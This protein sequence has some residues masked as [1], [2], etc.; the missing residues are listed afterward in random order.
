MFRYHIKFIAVLI[1]FL[2][3]QMVMKADNV[4][5]SIGGTVGANE[6][7]IVEIEITNDDQFVAFQF[8]FHVPSGFSYVAGSSLLDP[9][10][11]NGHLL[12][13]TLLP[14]NI[15]RI[16]AYSFSNNLFNGNSGSVVSFQ[17]ETGTTPGN[18]SLQLSDAIIGNQNSQNILSGIINGNIYLLAPDIHIIV[19]GLNFGE[20]IIGTSVSQNFN[21]Y[22]YGNQP[23]TIENLGTNNPVFTIDG[24]VNLTIPAGGSVNK[25]VWFNPTVKGAYNDQLTISSDDPDELA[26]I[27]PLTAIA[28]AVNELHT[29]NMFA[30][31]GDQSTLTFSIN[32]MEPFTGFQ[33]DL[34]M[35]APLTYIDGSVV[36][37]D[38]K[39][40]HQ[41]FA[42]TINEG[43]I[44]VIAF[45][46]NNQAFTGNSGDV[47]T[48]EFNVTGVAGTYPLTLTNVIV[49]DAEGSNIL[50][51]YYNGQ[52]EIAAADI[53]GPTNINFG[54]VAINTT[55]SEMFTLYN[56]GADTLFVSQFQF[57]NSAFSASVLLPDTI[58]PGQNSTFIVNFIPAV[59]GLNT[60]ILKV[61]SNDPDE[62]PFNINLIASV[63]MPNYF[64]LGDC[65]SGLQDTVNIYISAENYEPFVAFQF[66]IA[67]PLFST[68]LVNS[69]SFTGREQDHILFVNQVSANKI[70][71]FAYSLSQ[72]VFLGNTGEILKIPLV[73]NASSY[74]SFPLIISE[75]IM[76]NS[77]S[78]NILY[79]SSN[80]TLNIIQGFA[81]EVRVFLEGPFSGDK[82]NTNLNVLG[83]IPLN[84][85]YN[86]APWNYNGLESVASLPENT[87]DWLLL[88][89]RN[90]ASVQEATQAN[91]IYQKAIL[92]LNDGHT[93]DHQNGDVFVFN[94]PISDHLYVTVLHRNHLGVISTVPS[95]KNGALYSF[96]FSQNSNLIYGGLKSVK[97]LTPGIYGILSGDGN[98]DNE[99]NNM[100]KNDVWFLQNGSSGYFNG[101]FNMD[102]Q[103]TEDDIDSFWVPNA[104]N[105]SQLPN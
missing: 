31:S 71:V 87:V 96:D 4:M 69:I 91:I 85:P 75:A 101:D 29:G 59:E 90:A 40:N 54:S 86:L 17:I 98:A 61:F 55:K 73:V 80:G 37:T 68:C 14:G 32:N 33:F 5:T 20:V 24:P 81:S 44:R 10:R 99:I 16:F 67:Y 103:V 25:T 15:V 60:V 92:L 8:D 52:L 7:F 28:Y 72:S 78:Q 102:G 76:G 21:I 70:R 26:L 41:V 9:T 22:N 79:S 74:G 34:I 39:T 97:E 35:P 66:D 48:L 84:Q 42:N 62:N 64:N 58:L 11:S 65:Y 23:L 94:Q 12:N 88:D 45:S 3:A 49:G 57:T 63:F 89:F 2:S 100:D 56:Y 46:A 53:S 6:L 82:M 43:V 36:L 13:E 30:F 1:I 27:L 18:F 95:N 83:H 105:G 77:S 50:S 93:V 51:D 104:A 47:V 38:R 19:S